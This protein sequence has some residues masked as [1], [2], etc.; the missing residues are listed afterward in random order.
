MIVEPHRHRNI[1]SPRALDEAL[2]HEGGSFG[3]SHE[4][5]CAPNK[6]PAE[7]NSPVSSQTSGSAT[8]FDLEPSECQIDCNR[9]L[10]LATPR[11]PAKQLCQPVTN[12]ASVEP[13]ST[14][15]F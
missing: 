13:I 2:C 9:S 5:G 7:S 6:R 8:G 11:P 3:G 15:P 12:S 14:E 4:G 1:P 10:P